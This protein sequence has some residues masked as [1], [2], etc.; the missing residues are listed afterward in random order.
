MKQPNDRPAD[1]EK[2]C[3]YY[4]ERSRKDADR[5]VGVEW[6]RFGVY[7]D[8][9]A[10]VPYEGNRGYLTIL[11]F[12]HEKKGWEIEDGDGENIFTLLRG[13]SRTTVEG[14]GKPEIS[15]APH[16]SLHSLAAEIRTHAGEIKEI[17]EKLGIAWVP[18]GLQ[19]FVGE[20]DI[21]LVPKKRYRLWD[22]IFPDHHEWMHT[23]MKALSGI[24]INFDYTSE[25][26]LIRKMKTLYRLSP[27][28]AALFAN[29]PFERGSVAECIG[30]RRRWIFHGAPGQERLSEGMLGDGF[31]FPS[32][33]LWYVRQRL[34]I[35]P[36]NQDIV[37]PKGWTFETWMREG[38]EGRFPT[39]SD[40]DQHVKTRWTDFRFRPG[41]VEYRVIDTLPFPLLMAATAFVKGLTF[42]PKGCAEVERLTGGWTEE[43]IQTLHHKGCSDGLRSVVGGTTL[44]T[45]VLELLAVARENLSRATV[46]DDAGNNESIF[47]KP[48]ER[49]AEQGITPAEDLLAFTNGDPK[50]ILAWVARYETD[51]FR[52]N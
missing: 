3:A 8:T 28:M 10:N 46:L 43:T 18:L 23:Y 24:H 48:I 30:M 20:E 13:E 47:L 41:Y 22:R 25:E 44:Q 1:V 34:I 33:V 17:S 52:Q 21:P 45:L 40:F 37:V 12:L 39:F 26:H 27:I 15:S 14:D 42:D 49:F 9:L 2:I 38:Y 31:T 35:F 6:E 32:W 16:A 50:K 7:K 51:I 11:K 29:S 36:F 19:P 5:K 4:R